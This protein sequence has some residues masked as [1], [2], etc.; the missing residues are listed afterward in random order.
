MALASVQSMGGT[1]AL[2]PAYAA[3]LATE[4]IVPDDGLFLHVKNA[5]AGALTVTFVDP[6]F[7]PA[8]SVATN[9]TYTVPATTGDRMIPLNKNLMNPATGTIQV[10]FSVQSSVTVALIRR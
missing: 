2:T 4:Q 6:G 8:G 10:T 5:N 9:Q 1:V 7:T 3:P